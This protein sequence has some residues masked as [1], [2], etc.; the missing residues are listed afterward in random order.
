MSLLTLSTPPPADLAP[1]WRRLCAYLVDLVL[2]S[3][4]TS[5]LLVPA[6][7]RQAHHVEQLEKAL[8]DPALHVTPV[9]Y[10]ATSWFVAIV[11]AVV[12]ALYRV[13]QEAV[14]GRTLGHRLFGLRVVRYDGDRRIGLGWA[15]ARYG[16]FYGVNVIP[17]AGPIFTVVNYLWCVFDR[18]YHQCL[19]D[20]VAGTFVL[21]PS[22]RRLAARPPS[23]GSVVPPNERIYPPL[24]PE[25]RAPTPPGAPR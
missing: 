12:F 15:L 17:Y 25:R 10:W 11:T 19:H 4:V 23:D 8:S 2:L 7:G 24:P 22:G 3:V 6:A 14:A 16:V 20:K 5:P 21:H 18:Y 9:P 13:P 1:R